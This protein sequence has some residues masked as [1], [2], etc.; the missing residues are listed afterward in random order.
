MPKDEWLEVHVL[1]LNFN[2]HSGQIFCQIIFF[3]YG[4]YLRLIIINPL[5]LPHEI[6]LH[7]P[8]IN[9]CQILI[10]NGS[11]N[12]AVLFVFII[13]LHVGPMEKSIDGAYV[14]HF[15]NERQFQHQSLLILPLIIL[16]EKG[17]QNDFYRGNAVHFNRLVDLGG[18]IE[19]E[20]DYSGV[21]TKPCNIEILLH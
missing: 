18:K 14:F 2:V 13:K 7:L 8:I 11:L 9:I 17:L 16:L 19:V 15:E 20:A 6:T 12:R 5:K 1:V 3:D 21:F 10:Y 4:A